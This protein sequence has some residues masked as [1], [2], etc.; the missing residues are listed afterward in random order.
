LAYIAG[1]LASSNSFP[2]GNVCLGGKYE[3]GP[4]PYLPNKTR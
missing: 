1:S 2:S 4:V 3:A